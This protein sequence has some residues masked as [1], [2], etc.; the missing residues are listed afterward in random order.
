MGFK[1]SR[2]YRRG[3]KVAHLTSRG[4]LE[5]VLAMKL[6]LHWA[7][8][9]VTHHYKEVDGGSIPSC[10]STARLLTE[11]EKVK[12]ALQRVERKLHIDYL[13]IGQVSTRCFTSH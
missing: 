9:K 13:A 4:S 7:R 2:I 12:T 10:T 3:P 6:Y 11:E 5:V 8:R 1:K